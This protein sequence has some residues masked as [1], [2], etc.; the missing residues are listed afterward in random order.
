[1]VKAKV[2][3][4]KLEDGG[5]KKM[6]LIGVAF[7]PMIKIRGESDMINWSFTLINKQF[8]SEY[9]TISEVGFLMPN[10]PHTILKSGVEFTLFEGAKEIAYG[11][12]I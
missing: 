12:I 2:F 4:K 5:K 6:P 8:I 10:A 7:Y 3:W 11:I 1:M 9:E